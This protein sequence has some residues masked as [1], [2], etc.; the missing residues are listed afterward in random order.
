V[1]QMGADKT[2]RRA[3]LK[4]FWA[5]AHAALLHTWEPTE[6]AEALF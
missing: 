6:V 5:D 3:F 4:T 2:R 1:K